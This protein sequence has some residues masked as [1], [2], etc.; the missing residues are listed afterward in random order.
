M[1]KRILK[2][3]WLF[4]S[5]TIKKSSQLGQSMAK[6]S[7]DLKKHQYDDFKTKLNFL[8]TLQ[9]KVNRKTAFSSNDTC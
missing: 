1:P 8:A 7:T 9:S 3:Y 4:L 2:I 6:L 5:G